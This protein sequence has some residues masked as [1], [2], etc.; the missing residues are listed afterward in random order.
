M[1][2]ND[3]NQTSPASQISLLA[4][5]AY[6]FG[7][8]TETIATEALGYILSRSEAA[9]NALRERMAPRLWRLRADWIPAYAGMTVMG[10]RRVQWGEIPAFAGMTVI[11]CGNDGNPLHERRRLGAY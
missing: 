4:Y 5:L 1:T 2:T 8:Q 9:R 3:A 6:K 11:L 10:A 7:G